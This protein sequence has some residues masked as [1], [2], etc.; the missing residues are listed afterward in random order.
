MSK[1]SSNLISGLS[2]RPII[3]GRGE[4]E[5]KKSKKY[6]SFR[7]YYDKLYIDTKKL[8]DNILF[9]KYIHNNTNIPK[10]KTQIISNDLKDLINDVLNDRYN[11]KLYEALTDLDKRT[12]KVFNKAFKF[13]LNVPDD[14]EDAEFKEKFKI[15]VGSYYSGNYSEELK[16]E[17]KKY[18]RLGLA[19]GLVN[20]TSAFSLLYELS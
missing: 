8:E 11:K 10:L 6:K 17:L 13:N 12:F 14:S 9:C 18:V 5:V 1:E 16:K 7:I 3:H 20:Q 4:P 2:K 19:Q 15:L